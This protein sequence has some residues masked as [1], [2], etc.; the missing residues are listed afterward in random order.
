[1]NI[2]KKQM[3]HW[4]QQIEKNSNANDHILEELI[5]CKDQEVALYLY[6]IAA[7]ARKKYYGRDV[8]VRGLIEISNYCKNDCYY[9]GIRRSNKQ[10]KRYRLTLEEILKCCK[11]GYTLG[12]RT[13]VLQ[14]GEDTFYSDEILCGLISSIK[15]AYSDC[16]VTLSLGEKSFD[17]YQAYFR[18]GADRYL[19]RHE[20]ANEE[21][22]KK[23]HP[24]SM[25]FKKRKQ[26]LWDLK[27]I[28]YQVGAGCMIGSP[29]QNTKNLVEDIRFLQKLKPSM[30]GVGPF[31][32]HEDTPFHIYP[33]GD[34]TE[35]LNMIA[36][37]RLLFPYV[38]LP[39]TTALGTLH[40]QGREL[41]I[42]AGANVVMPNLSPTSVRKLY[43]LYDDKIC[44][45]EEAAE[46]KDSL[47][48]RIESVGYRVVTSRG[49]V[50]G[51]HKK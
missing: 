17:S 1:M 7:E 41:G 11:D 38:L 21:H 49:D 8:Y 40:P 20:T 42:Q 14:G 13:F 26:C 6:N 47:E 43:A 28:G 23:L 10:L 34:L 51:F 48:K 37:L 50:Y 39:S 16:A 27:K 29:G 24:D 2:D 19:L 12:F 22:Y 25:S 30:I 46:C 45:G 33:K 36:L 32:P 44:T 18:A 9:C 15:T 5:A 3:M 31:L 4:V 35:C